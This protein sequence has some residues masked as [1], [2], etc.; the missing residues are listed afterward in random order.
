M[1]GHNPRPRPPLHS[2]R[3]PRRALGRLFPGWQLDRRLGWLLGR[4]LGLALRGFADAKP[5][6]RDAAT[7]DRLGWT[8]ADFVAQCPRDA[9]VLGR[10]GEVLNEDTQ[11]GADRRAVDTLFRAPGDDGTDPGVRAA[12]AGGASVQK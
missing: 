3:F 4:D 8:L 2:R 6:G 9:A 1:L 10:L 7:R 5:E 12:A 11:A